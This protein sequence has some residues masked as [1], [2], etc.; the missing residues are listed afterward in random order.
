MHFLEEHVVPWVRKWEIAPGMMGEQGAESVH[1][2]FNRIEL[3]YR[4]MIHNRVDRL[5]SVVKQHHLQIS[6]QNLM[7]QPGNVR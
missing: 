2:Q 4:I 1:A 7:L 6:P 5:K 3:S